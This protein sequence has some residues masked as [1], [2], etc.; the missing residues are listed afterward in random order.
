MPPLFKERP[1]DLDV[2][3][4]GHLVLQCELFSVEGDDVSRHWFRGKVD[5][6]TLPN[7]KVFC[8]GTTLFVSE[9]SEPGSVEYGCMASSVYGNSTLFRRV[10]VTSK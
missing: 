3:V 2:L 10:R 4:G 7:H 8:D 6:A 1:G 9:F 5:V